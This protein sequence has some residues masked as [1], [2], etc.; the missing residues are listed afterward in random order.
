LSA[1][2]RARRRPAVDC[3]AE[4]RHLG[5]ENADDRDALRASA[6]D[7]VRPP[8]D[9]AIGTQLLRP[10]PVADPGRHGVRVAMIVVSEIASG[11]EGNRERLPEART[12]IVSKEL[13]GPA[14]DEDL[15]TGHSMAGAPLDETKTRQRTPAQRERI[16]E[17]QAELGARL[18]D[19]V[20]PIGAGERQRPE[21]IAVR[22]REDRGRQPQAKHERCDDGD[23]ESRRAAPSAQH[24]AQ[25]GQPV[26]HRPLPYLCPPIRRRIRS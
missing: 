10:E 8:D 13:D 14:V 9:A 6:G 1:A 11:D 22:E 5:T 21:E 26:G 2:R 17:A 15:G 18:A 20:R 19:K 4:R 7:V 12:H 16:G 23:S 24:I 3:S 25:V